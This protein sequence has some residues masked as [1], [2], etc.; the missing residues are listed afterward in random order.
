MIECVGD[1]GVLNPPGTEK[2][3]LLDGPYFMRALLESGAR[4]FCSRSA[5]VSLGSV[6]NDFVH[7]VPLVAR[8]VPVD[9]PV[10]GLAASHG[11]KGSGPDL[12]RSPC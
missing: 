2:T 11:I 12:M 3:G 8:R 7:P 4:Q 9:R 5:A 1:G 6:N 10:E